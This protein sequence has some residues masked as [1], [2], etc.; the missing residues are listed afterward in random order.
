MP[1][2]LTRWD[3]YAD[4]ADLRCLRS[5]CGRSTV[6]AC[7]ARTAYM[8]TSTRRRGAV[9]VAES[10]PNGDGDGGKRRPVLTEA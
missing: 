6:A 5:C 8:P 10:N 7:A 3:S 9:N 4:P 1:Y 2:A